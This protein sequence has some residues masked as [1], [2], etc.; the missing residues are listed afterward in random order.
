MSRLNITRTKLNY[1]NFNENY[2]WINLIMY[3]IKKNKIKQ[4]F[5]KYKNYEMTEN[6]DVFLNILIN[7]P[8]KTIFVKQF[9]YSTSFIMTGKYH[10]YKNNDAN[11]FINN[12][13]KIVKIDRIMPFLTF[14]YSIKHN[15]IIFN[16]VF[17]INDLV[18]Y[19]CMFI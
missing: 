7:T 15:K 9:N 6:E 12:F 16:N 2:A 19:I 4:L 1:I 13:N 18:R 3:S 14:I 10:I 17:H 11:N 8:S 5:D